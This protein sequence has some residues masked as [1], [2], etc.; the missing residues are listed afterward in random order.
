LPLTRSQV[1]RLGTRLRDSPV[2]DPAD[3]D[4]LDEYERSFE[5]AQLGVVRMIRES[6]GLDPT[7]R[8]LKTVSSII[9]KL[10][11]GIG[12]SVMQDIAGCRI[13]VEDVMLQDEVV[14]RLKE[15]PWDRCRE[16]DRRKQPSY[17]YRAVHLIVRVRGRQVEIQIRTRLQDQWAQISERFADRFEPEVKYGGG[18]LPA[19]EILARLAEIIE[20]DEEARRQVWALK[21]GQQVEE[22]ELELELEAL[23]AEILDLHTRSV[24]LMNRVLVTL[25]E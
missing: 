12:L 8:P 21:Y 7:V 17:G 25:S 9:A 14:E 18:P 2:P 20:R 6:L 1:E 5:E 11:R 13:V 3:L 24:N 15:L 22:P 10:R 19:R 23:E 4:L 16:V